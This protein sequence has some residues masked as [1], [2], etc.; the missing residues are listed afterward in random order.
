[1]L[2]CSDCG[3]VFEND[4]A[5]EITETHG[6]ETPPYEKFY[7]CPNCRGNVEKAK[8]CRICGEYD[9][10]EDMLDD[11]CTACIDKYAKDVDVCY[12]LG[13]KCRTPL[14]IN[15]LTATVYSRDE[16]DKILLEHLKHSQKD[17]SDFAKCDLY[18]FA[19]Y[20]PDD[21]EK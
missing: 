18:W 1:M 4:E 19:T 17:I 14:Y 6:M 5:V 16:I 21:E 11:V 20:L 8:K 3:K 9:Y 10:E 12:K 13:E 7:V 15:G 2:K